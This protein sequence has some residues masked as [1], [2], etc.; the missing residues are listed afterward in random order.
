VRILFTYSGGFSHFDPML[1]LAAAA[2]AAG[3]VVAVAGQGALAPRVEAA[4]FTAFGTGPDDGVPVPGPLFD[5]HAA[6]PGRGIRARFAVRYAPHRAADLLPLCRDWRPDLLV[7]GEVD[8]GAMVVA[9]HLGLP[10]TEVLAFAA[11]LKIR[12]D[13]LAGPLNELRAD[14]GLPIDPEMAMIHRHLRLSPFPP[15]FRHPDAPLPDGGVAFRHEV[16]SGPAPDWSTVLPG[17]PRVYFTLGTV[18][19]TESGDLFPRVLA[20]LAGL[21]VNVLVTVG[22]DVDPAITGPQPANVRVARFVPHADVLPHCD[23]IVSHGG[24]GSV[25]GAIAHGLPSVLLPIGADQ[26]DNAARCA[27]LGLGRVLDVATAT[28]AEVG[29]AAHELLS[30]PAHRRVARTWQAEFAALPSAAE[31]LPSLERLVTDATLAAHRN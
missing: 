10:H 18:F 6:H 4:G 2:K 15:G 12:P 11:G 31:L 3:H 26:L 27:E 5:A 16:R 17:A 19:N 22:R 25:L 28:P 21:P 24:S 7:C 1:P 14:Y 8:F 13:E 23:L 9:E 29:A 20:G 30:D